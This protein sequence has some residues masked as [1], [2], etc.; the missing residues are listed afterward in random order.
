MR[1]LPASWRVTAE[2]IN[3]EINK[4]AYKSDPP[5]KDEWDRMERGEGDC[6]NYAMEKFIRLRAAGFP[7]ERLR[8][9]TCIMGRRGPREPGEL[10]AVLVIDAPS[11]Q[12]ILSNGVNWLMWHADMVARGWEREGIQVLDGKDPESPAWMRREWGKWEAA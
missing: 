5:G 6:E 3:V 7:V 8:I 9:A 12:R 2:A 11:D 10:H 4:C 1:P